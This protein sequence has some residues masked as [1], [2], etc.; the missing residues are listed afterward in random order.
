M[1]LQ[2]DASPIGSASIAQIH[3]AVTREGDRVVLKVVKPGV[4]EM[5]E[6]DSRLLRVLARGLQLVAGR[7][8]PRRIVDEFTTYTLREVD[9]RLEADNAEAFAANFHDAPDVVFP[10]IFRQ[11][12]ARGVLC[13]AFLDGLRP[14]SP[15]ARA[16]PQADRAR[17]VELGAAA[18]IRMLYQDGLFHADL[19]PGNLLVLPGPKVGFI[20]LGMVGRLDGEL[21]RALMHYYYSLV[22]GDAEAAARYL[23]AVAEPQPGAD[24]VGFRR[25]VAEVGRRWRRAAHFGSFSIARLVLE[26]LA[27]GA[28]FRVYFPVE[29]VLMTKALI[30]YEGVGQVL[31]PGFDVAAVSRPHI[32]AVFMQQFHPLRIAREELRAMPDLVDALVKL[33]LLVTEGVHMLESATHRRAPSPLAGVR[34]SLLAGASLVAGALLLALDRPWPL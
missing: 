24:V 29:M 1:F 31:L 22:L 3:R 5:L 34:G 13:M 33:P 32:R 20:D 11:Y 21:R 16:L 7:W 2:V 15:E 12:S 6:R 8:M 4:R 18:I 19:H 10:A 17:L 9:L 30:T 28:H 27:R 25:E 14:D 23:T 26:S